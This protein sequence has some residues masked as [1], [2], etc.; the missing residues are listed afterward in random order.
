MS[1]EEFAAWL[2]V[3]RRVEACRDKGCP[4]SDGCASD[5]WAW[6]PSEGWVVRSSL[7]EAARAA[8]RQG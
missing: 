2:E 4:S 8:W 7:R 1:Q 6:S 3:T 5:E